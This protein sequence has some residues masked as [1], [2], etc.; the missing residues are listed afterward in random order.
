MA[1]SSERKYS[2]MNQVKFKEGSHEKSLTG[3]EC[4]KHNIALQ[5]IVWLF[6]TNFT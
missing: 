2:R 4:V 1:L 5:I 6:S 3:M